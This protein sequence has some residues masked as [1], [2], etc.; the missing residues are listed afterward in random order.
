[1][2]WCGPKDWYLFRIGIIP[3]SAFQFQV[4]NGRSNSRQCNTKMRFEIIG[5]IITLTIHRVV[6]RVWFCG[7]S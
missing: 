2:V 6:S 3:H 4:M 5:L 1:M 7:C